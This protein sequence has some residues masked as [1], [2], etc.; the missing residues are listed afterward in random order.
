MNDRTCSSWF[1]VWNF[2]D[3]MEN[4]QKNLGKKSK[5]IILKYIYFYLK[6]MDGKVELTI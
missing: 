3:F 1:C 6:G 4:A 2:G 5:F